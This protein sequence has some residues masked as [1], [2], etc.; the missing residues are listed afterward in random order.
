MVVKKKYLFAFTVQ[1]VPCSGPACPGAA[2]SCVLRWCQLHATQKPKGN[3]SERAHCCLPLHSAKPAGN[4]GQSST[5]WISFALH[6]CSEYLHHGRT[7]LSSRLSTCITTAP[8]LPWLMP[9]PC[10]VLT[11]SASPRKHSVALKY[12]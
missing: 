3:V 2:T 9:N 11:W 4:T 1:C 5:S 10:A 7:L 6:L 8:R 12:L